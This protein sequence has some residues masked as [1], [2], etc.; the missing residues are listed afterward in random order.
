MKY[1]K[2]YEFSDFLNFSFS[3]GDLITRNSV[4]WLRS[5]IIND[6]NYLIDVCYGFCMA[7]FINFNG[8]IFI[9]VY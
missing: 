9:V 1:P 5:F 2:I 4:N 8:N 6:L 7:A 3:R